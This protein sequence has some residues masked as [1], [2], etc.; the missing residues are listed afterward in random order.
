MGNTGFRKLLFP[1]DL[2]ET[3]YSSLYD[4]KMMNLNRGEIPFSHYKDKVLLIVNVPRLKKGREEGGEGGKV[5]E[6]KK[7][8]EGQGRKEEEDLK[9]ILERF[10]GKVEVLAFP[11]GQFGG[12]VG[13]FEEIRQS[14]KGK[15]GED[16]HLF[17]KVF[18]FN[19]FKIQNSRL[20]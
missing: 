11:C 7:R 19:V 20:R 17:A 2:V 10:R 9:Q 18:K 6:G 15:F 1:G 13:D 3:P 12:D 8:E 14:Y 16:F 5:E 4:I